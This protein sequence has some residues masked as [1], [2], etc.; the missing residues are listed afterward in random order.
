MEEAL[1]DVYM[2]G[3]RFLL[4]K[5]AQAGKPAPAALERDVLPDQVGEIQPLLDLVNNRVAGCRHLL[6][7]V[8]WGLER[9]GTGRR[10]W[11]A[12]D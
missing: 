9:P 4:M 5:R 6:G 2:K 11:S 7:R 12:S 8:S 1:I 10:K 3:R